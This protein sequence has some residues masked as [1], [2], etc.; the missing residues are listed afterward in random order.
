MKWHLVDQKGN[1][2]NHPIIVKFHSPEDSAVTIHIPWQ[3]AGVSDTSVLAKTLFL[4][5]DEG[6]GVPESY[7]IHSYSVNLE[8][9][10]IRRLS[11]VFFL[12][13]A[14]LRMFADVGG[15]YIFINEHVSNS[16]D[17]LRH[18]F[19]KT[20]RKRWKINKSMT[21]HVPEDRSFRVYVGGWEADGVD[22][23]MGHI[24]DQNSDCSHNV[25]AR[26]NDLMLDPSPV[27]YGGC[28][29]DNM[30]ESV[31]FHSPS[32]LREVG[33]YL[34]VGNGNPYKENCPFGNRTP[35]NFHQLEYSIIEK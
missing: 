33:S 16:K 3:T 8:K 26:I 10:W 21:V 13:P 22:K 35:V 19:G 23:V 27:G 2:F 18:G 14:E 28:E 4:Y 9:L 25:K 20:I 30:G 24:V 31:M 11:E 32:D 1:T 34:S 17:I 15:Q 12:T 7:R 6:N 5:W 29:D